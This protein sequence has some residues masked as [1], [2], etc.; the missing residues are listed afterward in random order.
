M[1]LASILRALVMQNLRLEKTL[2]W[3]ATIVS[4]TYVDWAR[5]GII[6]ACKRSGPGPC[7]ADTP[8]IPL[9]KPV[10]AQTTGLLLGGR[11]RNA[12]A[13]VSDGSMPA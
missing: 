13:A 10:S 1:R 12:G 5:W 3:R 8:P 11:A 4:R 7:P 6:P 2:P 9:P